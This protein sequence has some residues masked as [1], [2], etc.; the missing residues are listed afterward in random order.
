MFLKVSAALLALCLVTGPVSAQ[1]AL[2]DARDAV[3]EAQQSVEDAAREAGRNASEFLADNPDLGGEIIS[4]GQRLGLPG[5]EDA[6]AFAGAN[7]TVVPETAPPGAPV[8]LRAV[9]LAADTKVAIAF[10]NLRGTPEGIATGVANNRGVLKQT[11][12]VPAGLKSGASGVFIVETVDGRLR[13]ASDAFTIADPGPPPGTKIDVTGTLSNE[14]VECPALR[15]DDGALYTLTDPI[16]GGFRPGDRI[17]VTGKV[18]GMST[19]IQ[20]IPVTGATITAANR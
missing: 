20:G 2:D 7:L 18:A 8:E 4:L 10:G 14:G 1:S 19:C 9:G 16:A 12:K 17:H 6:K 13:L 3:R 5:F 15:G 11:V